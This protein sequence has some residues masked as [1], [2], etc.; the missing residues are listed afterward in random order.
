MGAFAGGGCGQDFSP[1]VGAGQGV[2]ELGGAAAVSGDRGPLVV[3][4]LRLGGAEGE[5]GLDGEGHGID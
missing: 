1:G 2:L 3:P 5:H 4:D